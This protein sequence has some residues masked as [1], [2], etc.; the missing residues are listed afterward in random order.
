MA[1]TYK[2]VKRDTLSEIAE[3]LYKDYGYSSWR[4]YM[5]YLVELNDIENP[6]F[7][8][9]GQV[10]NLSGTATKTTNKT[11]KATIKSF[12][13]LSNG[14]TV[15]ASWKWDKSHTD[16]Y[17]V[18]WCYK[19]PNFKEW[20]VGSTSTVT[21]KQ[22][23]YSFPAEAKQIKFN[24]RPIAQS[25]ENN[26]KTQYRWT[27]SWSTDAI[28]N[29][30]APPDTPSSPNVTI[31]QYKLK[32][33]ISNIDAE[34]IKF[35]V[36][37]NDKE[38]V[39]TTTLNVTTR[40]ATFNFTVPKEGAYKV[41]CQITLKGQ[42]SEWSD[43]SPNVYSAPATPS[44]ISTIRA[45]S[46]TSIYL[47]WA[48]V[49]SAEVYDIEYATDKTYFDGSNQT[50]TLSD[51]KT[52]HYLVT[53]LQTG[54]EYFFRLRSVR[55]SQE[56]KWTPIVSVILGKKPIA[57][58]TWSSTTTAIVGEPVT[59]FWVHNS[60]DGSNE[61]CSDIELIV[62]GT[63]IPMD[64]IANPNLEE[65]ENGG[66][67]KVRSYILDTSSYTEGTKIQWRIR[68]KGILGSYG[69]WSTQRTIDVY[70]QPTLALQMLDSSSA[71]IASNGTLGMLTGFPCYIYGL[72]GPATQA[73]IGY[74]LVV[75]ANQPYETTDAAGNDIYINTG[76]QIYSRYFDIGTE[77][78]TELNPGN[79]DLENNIEYTVSCTV[80]MDS[81]LNVE[82]T[83]SFQVSW[84]D[85]EYEPNAEIGVDEDS[86][87][88]TIRP[89]CEDAEG[90]PIEGVTLSVYRREFDGGFTEIATGLENVAGIFVTDP[91]P[92][93]DYARYRVVAVANDTGAISYCDIAPFAIGEKAAIIQWDEVWSSFDGDIPD[94]Y[95]TPNWTGSL[96]RLPY[97]LDVSDNGKVDVS[98]VPYI[99]RSHPTAYYG[100][101]LGHTSTWNVD[102]EKGD[103]ETIYALRRLQN[104]TGNAYVREPSGSGYWANVAVSFSQ[105][106]KELK[107]PVTLTITR[108]E[109]GM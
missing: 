34:K 45:E 3:R 58:T 74:S 30:N 81:G 2:V 76:D 64:P 19:D 90:N 47:A 37:R 33:T 39:A 60:E 42:T 21:E 85:L 59:L 11:S 94:E 52:N 84:E 105:K 83:L 41:R 86:V 22:A 12:G 46:D 50:T 38:L 71:E 100:T 8:V 69:D 1:D 107:V 55:E 7:I 53:G 28:Y 109:G 14:I 102:V 36:V 91:H 72:P 13:P 49:S 78:M 80:S 93:L 20:I 15:Y 88:T 54:A 6:D 67:V 61:R 40:S 23:T 95:E 25:R 77:L 10:L 9:I 73:P 103:E 98:I 75:T 17:E 66:E 63:K 44:G 108:V 27:A 96:L 101:Q 48:S 92:A 97:N 31:D 16:H 57:P 65:E 79:I 18:K 29:Y 106:H 51:I 89:Y 35:Q 70:A 82:S 68:T 104:W 4:D 87:S 24:V 99:G 5:D 32:A 26:G 62:D 56:S 43:Y